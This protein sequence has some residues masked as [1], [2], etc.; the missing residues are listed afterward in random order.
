[1]EDRFEVFETL[2][3][4]Q[5][6]LFNDWV[7]KADFAKV[8]Q[9]TTVCLLTIS[10]GFEVIGTSA[11]VDPKMFDATLGKEYSLKDALRQLDGYVGFYRQ[12]MGIKNGY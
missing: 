9:K 7:N 8:G 11:C 2:S 10:N 1:M 12:E 4:Y 6:N 3:E 5:Q